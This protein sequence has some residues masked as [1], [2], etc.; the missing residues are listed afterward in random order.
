MT[1]LDV[2]CGTDGPIERAG[3]P[4]AFRGEADAPWWARYCRSVVT[5]VWSAIS[6]L[7]RGRHGGEDQHG[8]SAEHKWAASGPP[9]RQRCVYP[10]ARTIRRNSALRRARRIEER[11]T[12]GG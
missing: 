6:T 10:G 4:L 7:D 11:V 8:R 5:F 3:G 1:S 2:S 9:A 12:E